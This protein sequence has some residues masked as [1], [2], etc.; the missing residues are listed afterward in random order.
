MIEW[1]WGRKAFQ[2]FDR[3]KYKP[4]SWL[5]NEMK[6]S[7]SH[8]IFSN[9]FNLWWTKSV[10][11]QE[12]PNKHQDFLAHLHFSGLELFPQTLNSQIGAW[13][14]LEDWAGPEQLAT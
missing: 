12:L 4:G 1:L 6:L 11:Q 14:S 2:G 13:C 10:H 9:H 7:G 5:S 3:P 8:H